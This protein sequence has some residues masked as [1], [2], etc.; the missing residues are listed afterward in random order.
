MHR[1]RLN[2]TIYYPE[3]HAHGTTLHAV[4]VGSVRKPQR[5]GIKKQ[6]DAIR[7]KYASEGPKKVKSML[8]KSRK[9][10]QAGLRAK[11]ER[12]G[13][14]TKKSRAYKE[15]TSPLG[16]RAIERQPKGIYKHSAAFLAKQAARKAAKK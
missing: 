16:K 8:A 14:T 9:S 4:N 7:A 3:R 12:E 11:A 13:Y 6:R 5:A 2:G 10:R 1:A 15:G